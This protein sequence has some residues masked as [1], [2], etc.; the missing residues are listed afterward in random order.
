MKIN[1]R[2]VPTESALQK[3]KELEGLFME[4]SA[5]TGH[6]I[7]NLFKTISMSLPGN[8]NNQNGGGIGNTPNPQAGFLILSFYFY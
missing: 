7:N 2:Q 5:K 3:A 6:N 4:V 8:E 1:I